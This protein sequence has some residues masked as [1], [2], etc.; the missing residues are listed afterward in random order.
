MKGITLRNFLLDK[1]YK[2]VDLSKLTGMSQQSLSAAF[3]SE[4]VKSGLIESISTVTGISIGEFY[5]RAAEAKP[6][7]AAVPGERNE[8]I[9]LLKER[10]ESLKEQVEELRRD[11]EE[12]R[13]DKE[14]LSAAMEGGGK[15]RPAEKRRTGAETM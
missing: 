13:R 10:I 2:I 4:N 5:G 1:G 12:L 6:G 9:A 11:K 3:Q 15:T 8:Y 7:A 14:L